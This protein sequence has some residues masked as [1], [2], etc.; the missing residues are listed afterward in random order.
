MTIS[1]KEKYHKIQDHF[2]YFGNLFPNEPQYKSGLFYGLAMFPEF[3][4][5]ILHDAKSPMPFSDGS[6][7]GFQS[8]DVFEHIPYDKVT[9]ILDD[10]FRCLRNGGIFRLSVPDYHSRSCVNAPFMTKMES[11]CVT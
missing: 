7:R 11:F 10:I 2:I 1:S 4:R 8:Q 5:D 3:D 9:A 6:I